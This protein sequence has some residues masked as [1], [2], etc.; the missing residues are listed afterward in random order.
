[1][2]KEELY[3]VVGGLIIGVINQGESYYLNVADL[4]A[5]MV[6]RPVLPELLPELVKRL[7][8]HLEDPDF[9]FDSSGMKFS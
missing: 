6:L 2:C 7:P 4:L 3:V 8:S 1:M 9:E 5:A